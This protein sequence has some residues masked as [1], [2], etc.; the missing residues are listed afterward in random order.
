MIL[1]GS[2]W[3]IMRAAQSSNCRPGEERPQIEDITAIYITAKY[4]SGMNTRRATINFLNY[5]LAYMSNM[6]NNCCLASISFAGGF[7]GGSMVKNLLINAG[8]VCLI[9]GSGRSPGEGNS[10]PLQYSCLGNPMDRGAWQPTV[11]G[12]AKESDMTKWL[13]NNSKTLH[14]KDTCSEI[15][16]GFFTNDQ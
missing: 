9:P 15:Q 3:E 5:I 11:Y 12:V 2:W 4:V 1:Q 14:T 13:N 8:H 6:K 10:N 7:P 16:R